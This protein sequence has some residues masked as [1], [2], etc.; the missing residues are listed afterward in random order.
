MRVALRAIVAAVLTCA[1]CARAQDAVPNVYFGNLHSHTSYSD[2]SGTPEQAYTH[3]R[4]VAKLDFL[5]ITEH[6]HAAAEDGA[7]ADRHDGILI[8]KDHNL[9]VGPQATALIPTAGRF[10]Q[11]GTFIAFYGQEFSSIS[12]GNHMNV[13]EVPEVIDAPNGRFDQLLQWCA[14][15]SD[16]G[17]EFAV[18]QLNHPGE[19][20]QKDPFNDLEYGADDFGTKAQ[21]VKQMGAHACLIE[22]LN[23][24]A[25]AQTPG[26]RSA[27]VM[28]DDYQRYLLLGFRVAPTGDQDNHY[29]TWGDA[30]ESRTG[31]IAAALS[32]TELL[33]AMRA[34][35]VYATE[36]RNLK[37]VFKVNGHLCG[38]AVDDGQ[39][40]TPPKT[41]C[42]CLR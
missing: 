4:D 35:H 39:H 36:D 21:W 2:G 33:K 3:A 23:G 26:H 29:M 13:F 1:S 14:Q 24:P 12:K 10:N 28:E 11:D 38:D 37:L 17:G 7:T 25:M 6:N 27:E 9:Y 40:G 18:L 22:L 16:S 15:H 41:W 20:A 19:N 5:A 8:G 30:T 42:A 34:R 31:I 32:K